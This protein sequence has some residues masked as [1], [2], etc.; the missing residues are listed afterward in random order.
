MHFS[1]LHAT[2][3]VSDVESVA[4]ASVDLFEFC[5]AH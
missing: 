2:F 5:C 3:M 1:D 4:G